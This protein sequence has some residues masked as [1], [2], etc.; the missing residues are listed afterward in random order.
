MEWIVQNRAIF[1]EDDITL[2]IIVND[3]A[4]SVEGTFGL[5]SSA[6]GPAGWMTDDYRERVN[7][8]ERDSRNALQMVVNWFGTRGVS[9]LHN[10]F[11]IW[12][13]TFVYIV[14][15]TSQSIKW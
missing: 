6:I 4:I 2:A 11:M 7:Q 10:R 1:P 3:D 13:I 5:E 12:E 8:V 15:C 14:Y 9:L